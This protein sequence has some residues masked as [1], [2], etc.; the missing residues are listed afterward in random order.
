VGERLD[1]ALRWRGLGWEAGRP[2]NHEANAIAIFT[3]PSNQA[4]VTLLVGQPSASS[5]V[6]MSAIWLN[7]IG[8]PV[9]IAGSGAVLASAR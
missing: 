3:G 5:F 6:V 8:P 1:P 4:P 2:A 7:G 9:L